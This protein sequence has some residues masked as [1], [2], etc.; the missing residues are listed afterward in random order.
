M[1]ITY[2]STVTRR[3]SKTLCIKTRTYTY[4][5][6]INI[7]KSMEVLYVFVRS[8]HKTNVTS[9][10]SAYYIC[11]KWSVGWLL[12]GLHSAVYITGKHWRMMII[13]IWSTQ[14]SNTGSTKHSTKYWDTGCSVCVWDLSTDLLAGPCKLIQK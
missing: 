3:L 4:F 12:N 8:W 9:E 1:Q 14:W 7:G 10:P 5:K 13:K 2:I 6:Y 11:C